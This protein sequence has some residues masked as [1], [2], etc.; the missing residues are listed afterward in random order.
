VG[1]ED[2]A[3]GRLT[4]RFAVH[5][6]RLRLAA[7]LDELAPAEWEQP[8]LCEGWRVR[9]VVAHV[10]LGPR[11]T[12]SGILVDLTRARGDFHRAALDAARRKAAEP[13]ALLIAELRAAADSDR[14][15][16]FTSARDPL[17]GI[18]VHEQ[19]IAIPLRRGMP[20]PVSDAAIAASRMWQNPLYAS[21]K[22]L[23]GLRAE[24]TDVDWARGGGELVRGPIDAILL[25]LAGRSA[26]VP[27]MDGPGVPVLA[28]RLQGPCR[29]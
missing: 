1:T 27:R 3:T 9:D 23:R 15:V 8:S 18:L 24:A 21:R 2:V 25:A 10:V 26:G 20:M 28:E 22:R 12:I 14:R 4:V 13:T 6:E 7:M 5:R 17:A 11:M 19:D 29:P 16:P